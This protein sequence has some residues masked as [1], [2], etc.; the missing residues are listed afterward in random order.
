MRFEFRQ[1]ETL[2][3]LAWCARLTKS[4]Q[5]VVV[6]HGAW[7][8]TREH[9]FFEG[10][11]NGT[12]PEGELNGATVCLGSGA[13]LTDAGALFSAPTHMLERLHTIRV[14]GELVV[15]NSLAFALAE[16]DDSYDLDYK[17]Y[18]FD[19][20]SNMKGL[21][22][23]KDRVR[24]RKGNVVRLHYHCDLLIQPDLGIRKLPKKIPPPFNSFDDYVGFLKTVTEGVQRNAGAPERKISYQP[25]ATISSG[26]DSP[27]CALFAKG[28]GCREAVTF[29]KAR[30][31]YESD[32]DSGEAIAEILG[33]KV[34]KFEREA[35]LGL[36]S[37]PEAEF[38]ACGAGGEEVVFA[39]VEN[40]LPGKL[41]FTGY[42]GDAVWN[43]NSRSVNRELLMLYPGGSSFGEF[44]LRVGFIHFPLPAIGY[45]NHPSIYAISNAP[46]MDAW[47]IGNDYDRSIP[48][49]LLEERGVPRHLFGQH[50]MAITQPLWN[51]ERLES[52]MAADSF[53]DLTEFARDVPLFGS[54]VERL[55]FNLLRNLY[56]VNLRVNWK[57]NNIANRFGKAVPEQPLVSERY[58]QQL[59]LSALTFH[60]GIDKVLTRYKTALAQ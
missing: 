24:T 23:Y 25:L 9:F 51:T 60:W 4:Q 29:V 17:F 1:I 26:Y 47:V 13:A 44:R 18:H 19:L 53:R 33:L 42:L 6:R 27:A 58:S 43:R 59:G 57:L 34:I 48:R 52:F 56:E 12:F 3:R 54:K 5:A 45:I 36:P 16:A 22:K 31:G 55:R 21:R 35:Y 14:G 39:P 50:K 30:P 15:S 46:E 32:D 49:R 10:A 28:V 40:V 20:M 7:V 37:F 41:F 38:L 11:W 2:P 8:E